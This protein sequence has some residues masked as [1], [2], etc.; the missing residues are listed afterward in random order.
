M[1]SDQA[2]SHPWLTCDSS[3]LSAINL[4]RNLEK[5][6]VFNDL[7]K[8]FRNICK[9]V[10]IVNKFGQK[11]KILDDSSASDRRIMDPEDVGTPS[12]LPKISPSDN[13]VTVEVECTADAQ[14]MET[15]DN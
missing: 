2:L 10:I 7:R 8:R 13:A 5:L 14:P 12:K 9:K 6:R 15:R 1:T 4:D 3:V 11:R